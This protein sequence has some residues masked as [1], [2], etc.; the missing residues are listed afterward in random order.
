[1]DPGFDFY[2]LVDSV[3]AVATMAAALQGS[4]RP[5]QIL[6]ELGYPGGRS[7]CRTPG[8][9]LE[10]ATAVGRTHELALVGVEGYEAGLGSDRSPASLAAVDAF[11]RSLGDV[12]VELGRRGL[13]TG[14]ERPVVT[15]GGSAFFDRAAEILAGTTSAGHFDVVLRAGA[16]VTHDE[17]VYAALSPV[18]GELETAL[19]LWCTVLSRPE[20]ELAIVG[21]GRRDAPF[22]SGYP[23]PH[24][25]QGL[26]GVRAVDSLAVL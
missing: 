23:L 13:L 25:V 16:Y 18:A 4:E 19:E 12:A 22:D 9:A 26:G 24:L 11:L 1:A 3:D 17:G 6:V 5:L 7:G 8:D 20:P 14:R 15:A 21:F 2:C 10:V